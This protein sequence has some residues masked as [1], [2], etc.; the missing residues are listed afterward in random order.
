[1][2]VLDRLKSLLDKGGAVRD[3]VDALQQLTNPEMLFKVVD[4]Y[5]IETTSEPFS[6]CGHQWL[7]ILLSSF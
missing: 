6:Y 5:N 3:F 1:M 2:C 7:L 4:D